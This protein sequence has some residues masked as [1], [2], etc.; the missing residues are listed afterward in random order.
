M[1]VCCK[2]PVWLSIQSEQGYRLAHKKMFDHCKDQYAD[3]DVGKS[4]QAIV[5]DWSDAEINDLKAAIGDKLAMS[6]LRAYKVHWLHSCQRV[7]SR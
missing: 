6:P 4:F 7:Y 2:G 5:I 1:D 3:F